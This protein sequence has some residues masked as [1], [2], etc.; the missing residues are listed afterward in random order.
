M[1]FYSD[2][3]N[4]FRVNNKDAIGGAGMTQFGRALSAL[5]ID[6]ICANSPPAKGR[7]ERAFGTSQDRLVKDCAWPVLRRWRRRMPGYLGSSTPTTSASA[8]CRR[9]P[10][11]CT[12][13]WRMRTTSPK[14][15]PGGARPPIRFNLMS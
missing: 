6:I 4:I 10:R 1:A 2:K 14:S 3:H 9:M 5:N 15:W 11:I 7:V 13:H 8:V 12:G